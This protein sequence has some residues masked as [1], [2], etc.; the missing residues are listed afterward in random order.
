MRYAGAFYIFGWLT[1]IL[2]G[3]ML[4][5]AAFAV[6]FDETD[7]AFA[8]LTLSGLTAFVGGGLVLTLRGATKTAS[9]RENILLISLAWITLPVFAALPFL[10]TQST[11]AFS[12]A[13][14]E[15]VSGLTTTGASALGPID[16]LTEPI[17]IWRALLQVARRSRRDRYDYLYPFGSG[18]RA[19]RISWSIAWIEPFRINHRYL[20]IY[21]SNRCGDLWNYYPL[22]YRGCLGEWRFLFRLGV[23]KPVGHF[24]GRIRLL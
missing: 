4:L 15:A 11:T 19:R 20:C 21:G 6:Y 9:T 2:A 23:L 16:S 12:S 13:Y 22:W 1:F 18:A 3:A 7:V 10:A 8:F 24:D 17:L 14:F 5:P